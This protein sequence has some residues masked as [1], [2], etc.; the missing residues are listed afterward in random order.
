[1]N[2]KIKKIID[3]IRTFLKN[4]GDKIQDTHPFIQ[5][6]SF[7][8]CVGIIG[9]LFFTVIFSH[10]TRRSVFFFPN[11][12]TEVIATEIRYLPVVRGKD[13]TLQLYV[14]EV[15]LGSANPDRKPLFNRGTT[16][17]SCFIRKNTAYID[18]SSE[19][20]YPESGITSS[21]VATE[22]FKKNVCTNFRYI[23]KIYL[24]FEGIEVYRDNLVADAN[25]K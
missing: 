19:A 3:I 25:V 24:Y 8:V 2:A 18:L 7:L 10:G 22:I 6:V 5:I 21:I 13:A 11:S 15:L 20:A 16:V 14:S 1:M 23:D 9:I 4:T 12:R 17:L